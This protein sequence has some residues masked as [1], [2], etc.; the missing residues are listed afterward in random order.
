M[1]IQ[2]QLLDPIYLTYTEMK[3]RDFTEK[4]M[5]C[6][7]YHIKSFLFSIDKPVDEIAEDDVQAYLQKALSKSKLNYLVYN[8]LNFFFNDIL[9]SDLQPTETFGLDTVI[10]L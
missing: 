6:Y 3:N 8:S 2:N 5:G 9:K 4:K 7:L 1:N 10:R